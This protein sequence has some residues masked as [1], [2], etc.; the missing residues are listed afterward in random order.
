MLKFFSVDF[1][2]DFG[3]KNLDSASLATFR[4]ALEAGGDTPTL[5]YL[6]SKLG[7]DPKDS[8][9]MTAGLNVLID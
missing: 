9:Q 5:K 7:F 8:K 4:K 1:A 3:L 2:R 6:V